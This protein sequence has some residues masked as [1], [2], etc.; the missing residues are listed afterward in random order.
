VI[1]DEAHRTQYGQLALNMR[2]H[3]GPHSPKQKIEKRNI[4]K[5]EFS[6]ITK[7]QK[8]VGVL[9]AESPVSTSLKIHDY[10]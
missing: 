10:F 4:G 3:R 1:T 9:G 7:T 6:Q 8:A 5:I 2:S